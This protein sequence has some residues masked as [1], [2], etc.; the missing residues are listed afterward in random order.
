[1]AGPTPP[2]VIIINEALASAPFLTSTRVSA[3]CWTPKGNL[4]VIAG[5]D[6]TLAQLTS[7]QPIITKA[8]ADRFPGPDL[9]SRA[10][11]CWSKL[12]VNSV[13]TGVT[14][15][16]VA[17]A[18]A[19]IHDELLKENPTYCRLRITQLPTWVRRPD[20]YRP[21]SSLSLVFAFKDPDGSLLTSLLSSRFLFL[22]GIQSTLRKWINRCTTLAKLNAAKRKKGLLKLQTERDKFFTQKDK[23]DK[24]VSNHSLARLATPVAS[25]SGLPGPLIHSPPIPLLLPSKKAC[26]K[27]RA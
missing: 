23:E 19:A 1:M 10:N 7:T 11:L 18:P 17:H 26:G 16:S 4:V 9:T 21:G 27:H 24:I 22:F 20:L 6:T 2:L 14:G 8:L 12:L 15:N 3:G 13:P 25:G 5:P